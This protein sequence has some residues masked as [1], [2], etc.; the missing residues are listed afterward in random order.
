MLCL[1][2]EVVVVMLLP[3]VEGKESHS[4]PPLAKVPIFPVHLGPLLFHSDCRDLHIYLLLYSTILSSLR[5]GTTIYDSL[6]LQY[7]G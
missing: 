1:L 3:G 5:S 7:L 4:H 6:H 2:S